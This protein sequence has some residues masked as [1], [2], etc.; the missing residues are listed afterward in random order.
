M[1]E[2]SLNDDINLDQGR[3][4]EQFKKN[5]LPKGANSS[6]LLNNTGLNFSPVFE[7]YVNQEKTGAAGALQVG[8]AKVKGAS[9]ASQLSTV[10]N[11]ASANSSTTNTNQSPVTIT[12]LSSLEQSFQSSFKNYINAHTAVVKQLSQYTKGPISELVK[13]YGGKTVVVGT[14]LYYI[15]NYGVA[16][17]YKQG[18][19]T[20]DDTNLAAV[21]PPGQDIKNSISLSCLNTWPQEKSLTVD[22]SG[23]S[24]PILTQAEMETFIKGEEIDPAAV[25][26]LAGNNVITPGGE[27]AWVDIKGLK[28]SYAKG[29][30]MANRSESCRTAPK[31]IT[32][33]EYDLI[34]PG[35][36]NFNKDS[37]CNKL[38]IDP[39]LILQLSTANQKLLNLGRELIQEI[40]KLETDDKQT[41]DKLN[42]TA[43][44]IQKHLDTL[45]ID[46]NNFTNVLQTAQGNKVSRFKFNSNLAAGKQDSELKLSS[47]YIQY[48]FWLILAIGLSIFT[49]YNFASDTPSTFSFIIVI[50]VVL[51]LLYKL[52][53]YIHYKLF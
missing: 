51:V 41:Q 33:A 34:N 48:L 8:K 42:T 38:N 4:Y 50:L 5:L 12:H 45:E 43:V 2:N 44:T 22:M 29:L 27:E 16:H 17:K 19:I 10:N 39:K 53:T 21:F 20:Y 49:F 25:C 40:S 9:G 46:K 30:T 37:M 32:K 14:Y 18:T 26:G 35:K 11:A 15:N 47:N 28:H 1:F 52:W 3:Q 36:G 7:G 31:S 23:N 6:E 24:L 13:K